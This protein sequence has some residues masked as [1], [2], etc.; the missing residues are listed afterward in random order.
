MRRGSPK[1]LAAELAEAKK[2]GPYTGTVLPKYE[3]GKP[4]PV[5]LPPRGPEG[6]WKVSTVEEWDKVFY[7]NREKDECGLSNEHWR[8]LKRLHMDAYYAS[9]DVMCDC[10]N[11]KDTI[12][13]FRRNGLAW[14]P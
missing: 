13:M 14:P 8:A 9:G 2:V 4:N 1:W 6:G 5:E 11:V 3:P 12:A 7:Y 10:T